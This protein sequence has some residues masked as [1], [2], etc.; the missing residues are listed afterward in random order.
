MECYYYLRDEKDLFTD[1]KSQNE[2]ALGE[3][4]LDILCS[5]RD[6]GKKIF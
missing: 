1:E 5:R 4:F 6:F 2:R 3:S